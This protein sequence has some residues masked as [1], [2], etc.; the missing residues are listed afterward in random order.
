MYK[1]DLI[2]VG[3]ML[4]KKRLSLEKMFKADEWP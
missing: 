2:Y 4:R 1:I 3:L